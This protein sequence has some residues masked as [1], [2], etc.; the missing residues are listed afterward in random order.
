MKSLNLLFVFILNLIASI[1]IRITGSRKPSMLRMQA[2]Y[3]VPVVSDTPVPAEVPITGPGFR[4][5]AA[6]KLMSSLPTLQVNEQRI[7]PIQ[8][9]A[10]RQAALDEAAE[11]RRRRALRRQGLTMP[12]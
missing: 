6:Q 1:P 8:S 12:A 11:R 7:R 4:M 5:T 3:I 9:A 2:P 10:A